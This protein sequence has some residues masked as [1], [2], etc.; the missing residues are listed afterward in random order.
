MELDTRNA[1]PEPIDPTYVIGG[2]SYRLVKQLGF[3]QC[4]WLGDSVLKGVELHKFKPAVLHDVVRLQGPLAMA[5]CCLRDGETRNHHAKLPWSEIEAR[6]EEFAAELS[7]DEVLAFEIPFY[8][9]LTPAAVAIILEGRVMQV[10]YSEMDESHQPP[11]SPAPGPTGSSGVSSPSAEAT[12]PRSASS[13]AN[14]DLLR[15]S[16]ISDAVSSESSLITAS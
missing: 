1:Q 4:R 16:R 2:I 6:A 7:P 11:P 5:I 14:G 8:R 9:L 13:S 15:P 10:M 12:S 3:R